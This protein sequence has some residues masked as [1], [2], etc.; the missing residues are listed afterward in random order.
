MHQ[1]Q[2]RRF[3]TSNGIL[4]GLIA[5]IP[6]VV[7]FA[8]ATGR[9]IIILGLFL[10]AGVALL[11]LRMSEAFILLVLAVNQ[12]MFYLLP[13]DLLGGAR[14][15]GLLYVLLLITGVMAFFLGNWEHSSRFKPHVFVF[16]ALT[17]LSVIYTTL[18]GQPLIMGI[19]AAK[20]F[21]L[22]LFFFVFISKRINFE[23]LFRYI[24]LAGVLLT[25]INNIQ[26]FTGIQFFHY[27]REMQRV[28]QVRFLVGDI[29]LNYALIIAFGEYLRSKKKWYL[30]ASAYITVTVIFQGQTRMAIFGLFITLLVLMYLM[31][32]LDVKRAVFVG[33]PLF[34]VMI[35]LVPVIQSTFFGDLYRLT[36]YEL[37]QRGGNFGVRLDT[38][39]YYLK[40]IK[41]SP[42]IGR[43]IWNDEWK[44]NNPEDMK[45]QGLHLSDIGMASLIFH[46]GIVGAVWLYSLL[47]KVVKLCFDEKGK[48]KSMIHPGIVG[49]FIFSVATMLT[50]NT[51]THHR[52]IIYLT[53]SLALISQMSAVKP[54]VDS[55]D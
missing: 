36:R 9:H 46:M 29:F 33:V 22:I 32:F 35:W 49:Y 8:L 39:D 48:I 15:Q 37:K 2:L 51:M 7:G 18:H 28:G 40:E 1:I 16:L 38:Y 55:S 41:K 17:I 54:L 45:H 6:L 4:F 50:L 52:A 14:Y 42:V 19:K 44:Q 24:V 43:G 47:L 53:L 10:C 11:Y 26:Y 21:F 31:E 3:S 20:S 5:C 30:M 27:T 25:F 12:E 13:E 34:V 23:R